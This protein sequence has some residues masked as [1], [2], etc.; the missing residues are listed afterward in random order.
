MLEA[1][2]KVGGVSALAVGV[3]YLLYREMIRKDV[4]TRN[5]VAATA[6]KAPLDAGDRTKIFTM[7]LES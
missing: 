7:R 2:T 1:L 4:F 3:L 6:R 5:G